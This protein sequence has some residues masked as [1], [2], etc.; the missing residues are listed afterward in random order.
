MTMDNLTWIQTDDG[1]WSLYDTSLGELQHNRAGAYT[2]ALVNYVQP[3]NCMARLAQHGQ[4]TVLDSFF[5]LGW[6]TWVLLSA[7]LKSKDLAESSSDEITVRVLGTEINPQMPQFW[8][9]VLDDPR[10]CPLK[11]FMAASEHNT[12]YQTHISPNFSNTI[13]RHQLVFRPNITIDIAWCDFDFWLA[14]HQQRLAEQVD[15]IFHDAYAPKKVPALWTPQIFSHCFDLLKPQ[16]VLLTY[17]GSQ[18][19]RQ[20]LS[21]CGFI[22]SPTAILGTKRGGTKAVKP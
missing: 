20:C 16:G 10:L 21:A 18:Q 7:L 1:S 8:P 14:E 5:G 3:S 6:N 17:S 11:P 2:E 4:L 9:K 19:I 22:V 12:Y 13:E 15:V